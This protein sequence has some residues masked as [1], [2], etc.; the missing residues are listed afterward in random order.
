[1]QTYS[2]QHTHAHTSKK[3]DR[4]T[5]TH[6]HTLKCVYLEGCPTVCFF[7]ANAASPDYLRP[8]ARQLSLSLCL[9]VYAASVNTATSLLFADGSRWPEF[10]R[11]R[12]RT[13]VRLHMWSLNVQPDKEKVE[14]E[15]CPRK[16]S[17]HVREHNSAVFSSQTNKLETP[18]F[19]E[20]TLNRNGSYFLHDFSRCDVCAERR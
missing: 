17:P 3:T 16:N 13:F 10:S 11:L 12:A 19:H 2:H 20:A 9:S 8:F 1:V 7:T 14:D 15:K 4:Q 5:H 18:A 6:T